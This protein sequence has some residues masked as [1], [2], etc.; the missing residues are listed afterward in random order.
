ME[1]FGRLL[2]VEV[3]SNRVFLGMS[4]IASAQ[5]GPFSKLPWVFQFSL[6]SVSS[7][8]AAYNQWFVLKLIKKKTK[9]SG[10]QQLYEKELK[11]KT[12]SFFEEK[13][14]MKQS[15]IETNQCRVN[16]AWY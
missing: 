3:I 14:Q 11:I 6:S 4:L 5:V 12:S 15:N 8:N 13:Q 9:R 1:K 10:L 2:R 16:S 7:N